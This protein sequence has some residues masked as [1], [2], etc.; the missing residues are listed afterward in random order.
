MLSTKQIL[1]LKDHLETSQNP[2]FLFDNDVDGLCSA[3][4]LQ[5]AL[6]RG[7]S[8]AIKSFP[9]L[10]ETYLRKVDELNSD[11]VFILDKAEIELD[12]LKGIKER[13]LTLVVIDH[14]PIN[15]PNEKKELMKIY[16]TAENGGEPTTYIVQNIYERKEDQWLGM[17]GCIGDVYKP[18]F[19]KEFTKKYPELFNNQLKPFEA[20][21]L[22]EIGKLTKIL[23]FGL[24]DTTTNVLKM[25]NLLVRAN[26]P[27][28][29]LEENSRTYSLHQRFQKLNSIYKKQVDKANKNIGKKLVFLEYSGEV[30]MS[31]EISNRLM[32]ENPEKL[33]IVAFRKVDS[34]SVSLRGPNAKNVVDEVILKIPGARGGGHQVA[35][36]AKIP[37]EELENFKKSVKLFLKEE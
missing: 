21:Y 5:R 31:A 4:I 24:K 2:L 32:F 26:S 9:G 30:S 11:Y 8:F 36:G 37:L 19:S 14:H 35:C 25:I 23:N 10:N 1:E 3:I 6:G 15:I 20:M 12:F 17:I 18:S 33:V 13:G 28:D 34:A 16:S 7:K 22:T 27:Y 29:L